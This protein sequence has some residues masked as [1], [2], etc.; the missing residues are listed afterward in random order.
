M[1]NK[2]DGDARAIAR[3][4]YGDVRL[5]AQRALIAE[6]V[7]SLPRAFTAEELHDAVA[8]VAP[9]VGLA[10]IY[11]AL[12][13]MHAAGSVTTVGERAGSAL[14]A[15]CDR[16]DH[17]HHLVCTACGTVVGV[18]C[19]LGAETLASAERAGHLV[20][21]HEITLYGLC[22]ECRAVRGEG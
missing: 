11:R 15:R 7:A 2:L 3:T 4:L 12:A 9:G 1:P 14:L 8:R 22:A 17:H 20:T 19:P 10:T 16:H 18:D 6:V 13:A 5:S 21:R